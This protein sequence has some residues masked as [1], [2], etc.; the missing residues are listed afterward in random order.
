M[1]FLINDKSVDG[2]FHS[3]QEFKDAVHR[4]MEIRQEIQRLGFV[5]YCHR[6]MAT[7]QITA[8][9]V[10]QQAVQLL[11]VDQR[12]AFMQWLTMLGPY[13]EDSRLHSENEW[14]EVNGDIVTDTA[15]GE[16]AICRA[17]GI[18]RSLV[19]FNPSN[20]LF[21]PVTVTWRRESGEAADIEVENHWELATVQHCLE[22]KPA[23]IVSWVDLR[24]KMTAACTRLTF[25]P[26]AFDPLEGHPFVL[27]AAERIRVLL[28]TLDKL[29]GCFDEAGQRTPEGDRIYAEHFVGEKAWFSDSSP[30]EKHDFE[31]ELTFPHPE[32]AG[33]YLLCGW[34]GKVKTPQ[35]RIHF[36]WPISAN[37]PVFVV[38]VGPKLTKR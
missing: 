34:H 12:R 36:S 13:W 7:A 6:G 21:T 2:Q 32:N 8:D 17:R 23:P 22:A 26:S 1:N 9:A 5:L 35:I 20:W 27:G 16:V 19:S 38:Y 37:Q 28:F 18:E 14:L 29:R 15:V 3:V 33:K 10:M 11:R 24:E 25:L 4:V 30:S 31:S